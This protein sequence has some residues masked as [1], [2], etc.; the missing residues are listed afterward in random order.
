[1][2]GVRTSWLP[3]AVPPTVLPLL[4]SPGNRLTNTHRKHLPL[5]GAAPCSLT[6]Y[7]SAFPKCVVNV[8]TLTPKNIHS[9]ASTSASLTSL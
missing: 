3:C 4:L 8:S 6:L 7:S 1:M 2:Q 5:C 9:A